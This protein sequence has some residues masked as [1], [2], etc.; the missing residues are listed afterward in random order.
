MT[1]PS[2]SPGPEEDAPTPRWVYVAGIVLIAAALVLVAMHL[3]GGEVPS[4]F[5]P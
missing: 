3:A 5:G 1:G 4:H 2:R